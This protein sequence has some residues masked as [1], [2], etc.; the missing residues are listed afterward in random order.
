MLECPRELQ[1]RPTGQRLLTWRSAHYSSVAPRHSSAQRAGVC[2]ASARMVEIA[3]ARLGTEA[4]IEVG[5]MRLLTSVDAQSVAGVIGFFA[6][7]HLAAPEA[8]AAFM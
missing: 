3:R 8:L 2:R 7:H 5:D 4:R 6:M 1:T